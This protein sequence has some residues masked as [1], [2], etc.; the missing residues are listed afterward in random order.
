MSD[1]RRL[2]NRNEEI[3][4][5]LSDGK[6]LRNFYRFAAQNPHISLHDACQIVLDRPNAS[7]CFSFGEWNAMGRRITKGRSGVAYYDGDG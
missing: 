3:A 4:E 1:I 6:R 5:M 7:I 2:K